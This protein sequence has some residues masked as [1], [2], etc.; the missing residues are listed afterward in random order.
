ML[1]KVSSFFEV[2]FAILI[3]LGVVC[4]MTIFISLIFDGALNVLYYFCNGGVLW[5]IYQKQ[6][7]S[8]HII[9]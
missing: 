2:L 9:G 1:K 4:F 8:V 7:L 5:D 3:L 6:I